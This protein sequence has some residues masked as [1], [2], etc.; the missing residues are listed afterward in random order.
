MGSLGSERET[1]TKGHKKSERMFD[2][3]KM[4]EEIEPNELLATSCAEVTENGA[5]ETSPKRAD[6]LVPVS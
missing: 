1:E 6:S 4:V 3:A 2:L 5:G